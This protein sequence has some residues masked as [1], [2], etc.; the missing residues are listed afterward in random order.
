MVQVSPGSDNVSLL[1][2]LLGGQVR[3]MSN[4]SF[5]FGTWGPK[6]TLGF[7]TGHWVG[8]RIGFLIFIY[9]HMFTCHPRPILCTP[10]ADRYHIN[11]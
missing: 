10:F 9:L 3:G 11:G 5:V 2:N 6:G 7:R 8:F 1:I 4:L